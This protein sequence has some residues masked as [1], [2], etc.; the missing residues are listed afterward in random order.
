MAARFTARYMTP[1]VGNKAEMEERAR[2]RINNASKR[3]FAEVCNAATVSLWVCK[4]DFLDCQG[5]PLPKSFNKRN[6]PK[7]P[8][9]AQRKAKCLQVKKEE[10]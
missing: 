2:Q 6:P 1:I 4:T 5:A 3:L 8:S 9:L 7:Y 10:P